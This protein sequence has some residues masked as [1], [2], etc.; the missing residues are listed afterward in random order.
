MNKP[1][2]QTFKRVR[3]ERFDKLLVEKGTVQSH[4]RAR[5]LIIAGKVAVEGQTVD[6]P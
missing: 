5:A 1:I 4:E 2:A 3:K 6:K